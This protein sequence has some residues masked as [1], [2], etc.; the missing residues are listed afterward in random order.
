MVVVSTDTYAFNQDDEIA[1]EV[2]DFL[3]GKHS[4]LLARIL[5]NK[6]DRS[7]CLQILDVLQSKI[8]DGSIYER[9]SID[10]IVAAKEAILTSNVTA[11]Y[12]LDTVLFELLK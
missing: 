12:Q 7:Q 3:L 10:T 9:K 2:S 5:G 4:P 6:I 11:K 8:K 1:S